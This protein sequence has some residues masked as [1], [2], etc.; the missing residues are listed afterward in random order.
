MRT[1]RRLRSAGSVE[2]TPL[3]A[4][5]WRCGF[6][7][8]ELLVT[9][10]VIAVL[11]GLLLPALGAARETARAVQCTSNLRQLITAWHLYADDHDGRAMPLAY[12]DASQVGNGDS[13]YWW[14]TA[15][16][17]SGRVDHTRGLIAPYL[18]ESPLH[19][20]SVFECPS[21]PWGSY[22]AQ[23]F[24]REIT[25]TYG[26]NGYYLS[27]GHTPGWSG[28]IGHRPW[29]RVSQVREPSSLLVFADTLLPGNPPSNNALL[30]PPM[31]FSGSSGWRE[32]DSPTTAFRHGH[33]PRRLG[34]AGVARADG[35]AG[36]IAAESDWL[37]H[38]E[39]GIGS[40]GMSNDPHYVPDW[41][42]W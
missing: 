23:G 39:L 14:G 29:R 31:L 37:T 3:R 22:R 17:I 38:P 9:M 42:G 2:V 16:N 33:G 12:T 11:I 24:A 28:S 36:T 30:D 4:Q 19:E 6:T 1:A 13:V 40:L 26:Y 15:G 27:P 35:S 34:S 20:R 25:S 41:R 32:N 8:I 10:A 5:S 7:L 18:G 21:Q